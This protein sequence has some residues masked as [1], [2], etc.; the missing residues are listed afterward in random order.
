[1]HGVILE[2]SLW[3][4]FGTIQGPIVT[5][6]FCALK[7]IIISIKENICFF[8]HREKTAYTLRENGYSPD[9]F[10]DFSVGQDLVNSTWR[11]I[12]LDQAGLGLSREYLIKGVENERVQHYFEYMKTVRLIIFP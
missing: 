9:I 3:I 5:T 7:I 2:K 10:F 12:Y 1:M 4:P 6:Y 8:H 11:T